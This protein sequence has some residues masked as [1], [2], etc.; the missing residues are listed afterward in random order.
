MESR[1]N[2]RA[3][4]IHGEGSGGGDQLED[5]LELGRTGLNPEHSDISQLPLA[6]EDGWDL[7][8]PWSGPSNQG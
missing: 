1:T 4:L 8:G 6:K 2:M 5:I 3:A 7:L